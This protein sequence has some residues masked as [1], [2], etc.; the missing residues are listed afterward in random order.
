MTL[1]AGRRHAVAPPITPRA[2]VPWLTVL[3]LAVV[4]AF[5]DGFWTISLRTSAGEVARA[6]GPFAD[7]LR[8]SILALPMFVF[9]VLGALVLASSWFGPDV[10]RPRVVIATALLVAAAGTVAGFG[11]LTAS[12][13]YDYHLQAQQV[14]MMGSMAGRCT[15]DCLAREQHASLLLQ[16]KSVGYGTGLLLVTN[17]VVVGWMVA[18]RGGRLDLATNRR[19]GRGALPRRFTREDGLRLVLA[20]GLLGSAVVYAALALAG[21]APIGVLAIGLTAAQLAV[22][23]RLLSGHSRAV[24]VAAVVVSLG[25]LA[26][27]ASSYSPALPFGGQAL[28]LAAGMACLLEVGTLA[29]A[30]VLLRARRWLGRPGPSAHQLALALV[31]V[32]ALTTVG[33]AGTGLAWFDVLG[34]SGSHVVATSHR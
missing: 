29:G 9:A 23:A 8:E 32:L 1:A 13:A 20:A 31:A 25:T 24:L 34:P 19:R 15:G 33:L 17:L 28:G 30:V 5:A 16:V 22:A 12:S 27:S 10:R 14:K 4:L 7:W 6:Q 21:R 2:A 3:P 11:W 18:I 26:V